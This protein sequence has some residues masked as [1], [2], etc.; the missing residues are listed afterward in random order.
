MHKKR[1]KKTCYSIVHNLVDVRKHKSKS[2]IKL[3]RIFVVEQTNSRIMKDAIKVSDN[4]ILM[5]RKTTS[6]TEKFIVY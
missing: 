5:K 1:L 3:N 2:G 6:M 4:L